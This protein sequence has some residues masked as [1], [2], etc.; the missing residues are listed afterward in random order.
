MKKKSIFLKEVEIKGFELGEMFKQLLKKQEELT[1]YLIHQ[2]KE[3]KVLQKKIIQQQK[4]LS[5][6]KTK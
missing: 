4:H 5:A 6:H 3:I 2:Q 1:L